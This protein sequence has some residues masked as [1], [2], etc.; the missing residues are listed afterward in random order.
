MTRD[1][2]DATFPLGVASFDP[3]EDGVLIWTRVLGHDRCSW[4]VATDPSFSSVVAA[5]DAAVEPSGTVTVAVD[6][7][8]PATSY[9]YRFGATD[10]SRSRT[11]RTRTLPGGD[12]ERL[13]IAVVCCARYSQ[14]RFTVYKSVAD[15]DVDL[16]VHLGDYVYEDTKEG[17]DDRVPDPDHDCVTVDDYRR[18]HRQARSD[19]DALD[20]HAAHPMVAIWDDHD[21]ADNAWRGGAKTHDPAEQG[22]WADRMDA[23]L[24]AHQE[25]LPKRLA[26]PTD[27]RS[28]WRRL[29][30]GD[31]C[32]LICTEGRV[33]RD[34]QAGNEG[35]SPVDDPAR[36]MLGTAQTRWL[37][38]DGLDTPARW[39]VLLSGTVMS[40]LVIR[41]PDL[42]DGVLPEKY[43]VVDG[44]AVNTDQWDGYQA[45]RDRVAEALAR[46]DGGAL[47]LSGDIHSS[48]AIE[49]PLGP[50]GVPVAVELVCPPAATTPLGQLFALGV[51]ERAV[52]KLLEQLPGGRWADLDHRGYLTV[53]LSHHAAEATWWWVDDRATV[54]GRRWLIPR[55]N[56]PGL[57]D[58]EP[59]VGPDGTPKGQ[60]DAD[61][62][63]TGRR[64]GALV[65][66]AAAAV[67]ATVAIR[68]FIE[69]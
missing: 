40:E 5:G 17:L 14:S 29:D 62:S 21:L 50:D 20:L 19:P 26:D 16:V 52:P 47:V 49:G 69:R 1:R 48:W 56:P 18:R 3:L 51:A 24:R 39:A 63:K 10:G 35:S 37:A 58:P 60:A 57:I 23:A 55:S 59:R 22:P 7:L 8:A 45:D 13:R 61:T 9:W 25:F 27:L 53:D 38:E 41:A 33:H 67:A 11:G 4:E 6:G 32:S 34:L 15:A 42:L 65:L 12:A 28:A 30:A 46:R 2:D 31:L 64:T 44:R 54:Q 43:A 66:A 36:T 68:R